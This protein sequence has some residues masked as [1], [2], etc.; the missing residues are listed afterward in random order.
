MNDQPKPKLT[1]DEVVRECGDIR[2]SRIV[3][4]I[5]TGANMEELLEAMAYVHG[6]SD[7]MGEERK[8]LSGRVAEIYEILM[9]DDLYA[10]ENYMRRS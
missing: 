9:R 2:D 3:A 6:E 7:V 1:H 5:A 10:N 8:P 4:I